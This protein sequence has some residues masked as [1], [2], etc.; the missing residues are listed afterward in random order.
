MLAAPA[1][2]LVTDFESAMPPP[3]VIKAREGPSGKKHPLQ[4]K[5]KIARSNGRV[6]FRGVN[7]WGMSAM[8]LDSSRDSEQK[9]GEKQNHNAI[10]FQR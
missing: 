10:D 5:F 6:P 3:G 9:L 2:E 1:R 4:I 8:Q 7:P